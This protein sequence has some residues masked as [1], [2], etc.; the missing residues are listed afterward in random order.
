MGDLRTRVEFVIFSIFFIPW[1]LSVRTDSFSVLPCHLNLFYDTFRFRLSHP[2][3]SGIVNYANK[4]TIHSLTGGSKSF[5]NSSY[6]HISTANRFLI[7]LIWCDPY[8]AV[9]N[10]SRRS[11][12]SPLSLKFTLNP[13]RFGD[14]SQS[15]SVSTP[16]CIVV[17]I[18]DWF[19]N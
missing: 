7:K 6:N 19:C 2:H 13:V 12:T 3:S 14:R 16:Q 15:F 17:W 8:L 4:T 9:R 10:F 11:L 5:C 18:V 1:L